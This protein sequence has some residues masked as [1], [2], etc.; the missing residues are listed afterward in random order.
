MKDPFQSEQDRK[1]YKKFK[2]AVKRYAERTGADYETVKNELLFGNANRRLLMESDNKRKG[3]VY[4]Q[5]RT[6]TS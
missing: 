3:F 5:K 4:H 1:D 2:K 6:K